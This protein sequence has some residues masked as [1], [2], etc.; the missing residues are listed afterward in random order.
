VADF[1]KPAS[2]PSHVTLIDVRPLPCLLLV[3]AC[4]K[5]V[6]L[7]KLVSGK[8]LMNKGPGC[9]RVLTAK[10]TGRSAGGTCVWLTDSIPSLL[11]ALLHCGLR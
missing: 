7:S 4:G 1:H 3:M 8:L 6:L 9:D 5:V 2:S 11:Q 10:V